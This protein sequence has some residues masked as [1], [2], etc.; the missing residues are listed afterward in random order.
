MSGISVKSTS[1]S[2]CLVNM[3][4]TMD[5]LALR[6][7]PLGVALHRLSEDK[8]LRV[9]VLTNQP[10]DKHPLCLQEQWRAAKKAMER[11]ALQSWLWLRHDILLNDFLL[12][13][14][15][16]EWSALHDGGCWRDVAGRP[17]VLWLTPQSASG[18]PMDF[19][20]LLKTDRLPA[21]A[22]PLSCMHIGT[23]LQQRILPR[24]HSQPSPLLLVTATRER[25]DRFYSHTALGRSVRRLREAGVDVTV[26]ARCSNT[27]ALG[28][29]Y[30]TGVD[31]RHRQHLVVFVHDDVL[32]EDWHLAH[33]LDDA[34]SLYDIV[35]V[36]GNRKR[37]NGQPA[38]HFAQFVGQWSPAE[39]L[40]GCV[41]HDTMHRKDGGRRVRVISHY[42]EGHDRVRLID[43]VFMAMRGSTW[44]DSKL[45]FD[46]ALGF[47]FYDLDLCRQ[48][49]NMGLSM[50][51][52][53]IALTHMSV[54]G[55]SAQRWQQS[56]QAYLS[57]WKD[58][59][60]R[61]QT[62]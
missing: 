32:L 52:W 36:A 39:D 6:K 53:P 35:G 26:H 31:A 8:R 47:D 24:T 27:S 3:V 58:E 55:Y 54:G 46:P 11:N 19:G 40:V 21:E 12:A 7:S 15:L 57:K 43:G 38:W 60:P 37:L 34:L 16:K 29:V 45:R 10:E 28:E 25:A 20:A 33:R 51:I 4:S 2:S 22:G 50:G 48:A 14:R 44:L 62:H 23:S 18:L 9:Q 17:A 5:A 61:S 56:Y 49:E 30:N 42:G 41:G 1:V 13:D 59:M